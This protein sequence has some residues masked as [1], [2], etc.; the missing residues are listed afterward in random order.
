MVCAVRGWVGTKE[1]AMLISGGDHFPVGNGN[2]HCGGNLRV[3]L[4]IFSYFFR[5]VVTE[6]GGNGRTTD[7]KIFVHP[8]AQK[9]AYTPLDHDEYPWLRLQYIRY[10]RVKYSIKYEVLYPQGHRP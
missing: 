4:P 6:S 8:G 5:N 2:V 9:C 3:Q 1:A 7:K 10:C